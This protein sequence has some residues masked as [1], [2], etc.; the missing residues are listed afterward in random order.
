MGSPVR[1]LT[2]DGTVIICTSC[3][4]ALQTRGERVSRHLGE[5]H[6]VPVQARAGLTAFL[7][8]LVLPDPNHVDLL[9]DWTAPHPH[10]AV[11]TGA[12]CK[13][14]HFRSTSIELVKRHV[15]KSHRRAS[16]H[17]DWS[18]EYIHCGAQ[19]QSWT[20]AFRSQ[21]NPIAANWLS[22]FARLKAERV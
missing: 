2:F 16:K 11:Q 1:L 9:P 3:Q 22:L 4:Y 18:R 6:G 13:R 10:L 7:A 20:A 14:C 17:K 19:L 15:S 5:K 12:S 21:Y 8:E